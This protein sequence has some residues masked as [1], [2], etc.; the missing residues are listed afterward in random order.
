M[1]PFTIKQFKWNKLVFWMSALFMLLLVLYWQFLISPL[2]KQA[3]KDQQE[4]LTLRQKL[5]ETYSEITG[6]GSLGEGVLK[7][8]NQLKRVR[9][10]IPPEERVA[11]LIRLLS[12]EAQAGDI[13]VLSM[14]PGTPSILNTQPDDFSYSGKSV[15]FILPVTLSLQGEYRDIGEFIEALPRLP[16]LTT[17]RKITLRRDE[18]ISPLLHVS[19]QVAAYY[20]NFTKIDD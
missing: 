20:L 10:Y 12:Q 7:L 2:Q 11:E 16:R 18:T 3:R 9:D 4:L 14:T 17:L 1:R 19:C 6:V 5:K 8:Q 15:C 13:R